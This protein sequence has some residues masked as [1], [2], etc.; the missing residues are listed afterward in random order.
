[1]APSTRKIWHKY[2]ITFPIINPYEINISVKQSSLDQG[3]KKLPEKERQRRTCVTQTGQ[4]HTY[5]AVLCYLSGGV[6][7]EH[8]DVMSPCKK[9]LLILHTAL[10]GLRII[11]ISKELRAHSI[12]IGHFPP[13]GHIFL[14]EWERTT[15]FVCS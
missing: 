9:S 8:I 12:H 4:S 13:G 11:N 3:Q 7:R 10:F 1:M 6:W 15:E 14:C 2:R 5:H